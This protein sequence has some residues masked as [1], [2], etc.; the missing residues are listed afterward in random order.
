M[1]PQF[2]IKATTYLNIPYFH[3]AVLLLWPC[4]AMVCDIKQ[5]VFQ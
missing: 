2:I 4:V 5:A 3:I 1:V